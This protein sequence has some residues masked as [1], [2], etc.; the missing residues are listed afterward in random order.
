MAQDIAV[1]GMKIDSVQT[2]PPE[3]DIGIVVDGTKV[4]TTLDNFPRACAK[5]M[6]LMYALNLAYPEKLRYTFE[7]FQK[8]FL[9]LRSVILC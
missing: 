4:L 7:A 6:D 2:N 8:L 3:E 9:S 5:L 1:Q